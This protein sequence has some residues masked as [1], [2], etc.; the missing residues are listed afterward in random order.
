MCRIIFYTLTHCPALVPS[1]MEESSYEQQFMALNARFMSGVCQRMTGP[2][3]RT[4]TTLVFINQIREQ[5]GKWSPTGIAEGTPGGRSLKYYSTIRMSV[6]RGESLKQGSDI[7]GHSMKFK[8]IKNKIAAP[9]KEAAVNLIYGEGIDKADELFQ[10]ALKAGLIKQGGAWFSYIDEETG[11][12]RE[13]DDVQIRS[14]GRDRMLEMIRTIPQLYGEL[15]DLLRGV[16][17]EADEISDE[18]KAELGE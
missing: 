18:E 8:I 16:D 9:Y 13:I 12:I 6:R 15:E 11:E 4:G 7:V 5:I 3:Y 2:L 10:V 14:Q 17:V 1:Q